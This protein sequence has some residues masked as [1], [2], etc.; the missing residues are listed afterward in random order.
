MLIGAAF[1]LCIGDVLTKRYGLFMLWAWMSALAL[2]Q[3][4]AMSLVLETSLASR[5]LPRSTFKA[6]SAAPT[7]IARYKAVVVPPMCGVLGRQQG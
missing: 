6:F 3:I 1:G 4:F 5:Q 7:P 2:P